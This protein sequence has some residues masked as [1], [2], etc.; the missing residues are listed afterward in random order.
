MTN[1]GLPP[2]GAMQAPLN[3]ASGAL[4]GD[5]GAGGASDSQ[6]SSSFD[7]LLGALGD[8]SGQ[9]QPDGAPADANSAANA[10]AQLLAQ[11]ADESAPTVA[12]W[13]SIST[14]HSLRA[15]VLSALDKRLASTLTADS[16]DVETKASKADSETSADA[17]A[18]ANI[19]WASLMGGLTGAGG[20]PAPGSP[21]SATSAPTLATLAAATAS[22]AGKAS[23]GA[24]TEHAMPSDATLATA[25]QA[26]LSNSATPPVAVNVT[27]SITYLGLDPTA[28]KIQS[29]TGASTRP[30]ANNSP[31]A[32]S[33]RGLRSDQA[34]GSL[35]DAVGAASG[36]ASGDQTQQNNHGAGAQ[37][38]ASGGT[39][40]VDQETTSAAGQTAS[41]VSSAALASVNAISA[42][43]LLSASV[44]QLADVVASAAGELA[45][46][47]NDAA[48]SGTPADSANSARMAPVKELDVQLNPAS[49]GALTIQ[50]RLNNGSLSVTIQADKSDTLKLIEN[51]RG[52]I[53]NKLQSLNFS[54]DSLTVK[55]S[56]AVAPSSS[57]AGASNTGASNHGQAQQGQSGQTAD[58]SRGGRF[59][60]GA[61]DQ[62]QSAR[63]DRQGAGDTGGDSN[64]GHRVI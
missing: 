50:M 55:A 3:L 30:A 10:A 13:R 46:Q 11:S 15:G 29:A 7:A 14:L 5:R 35:S 36:A 38:R 45:S 25:T 27:R 49:L 4:V 37:D 47:S 24:A 22:V 2:Q 42:N 64:F 31:G 51:E 1:L 58:G 57:G 33:L 26:G 52:S 54:V 20:A 8:S 18:L 12:S 19:G 61:G 17:A 56:D 62:R 21:A 40:R 23:A 44:A 34:S 28:A 39:G 60:Q 9:T 43:G 63:Q 59:S 6:D 32:D 48:P 41:A 53:T 16:P